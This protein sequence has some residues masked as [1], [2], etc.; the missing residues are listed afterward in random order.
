MMS[1]Y[2]PAQAEAIFRRALAAYGAQACPVYREKRDVNGA[3]DG[4]PQRIGCV[5]GVRY[6]R[7]RTDNVVVDLPG[8]V[9]RT[10]TPHFCCALC[11]CARDLRIGDAIAYDG[12][13]YSVLDVQIEM[14]I[15]ADVT[16][17]ER[18]EPRELSD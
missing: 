10:E 12:T 9:A 11:G 2:V 18:E 3:A 8:V 6:D 1:P 13:W 7:G 16:V 14:G 17:R 5:Y 4:P 15:L